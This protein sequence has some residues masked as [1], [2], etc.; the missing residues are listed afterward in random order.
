MTSTTKLKLKNY[1]GCV[2]THFLATKSMQLCINRISYNTNCT[3]EGRDFSFTLKNKT[4]RNI[5]SSG[6]ILFL[7]KD[8]DFAA[9]NWK[10][11]RKILNTGAEKGTWQERREEEK[12]GEERREELVICI[13]VA[14][15][16][17]LTL[18]KKKQCTKMIWLAIDLRK[19]VLLLLLLHYYS[20]YYEYE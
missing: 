17:N 5:T 14:F 6:L 19:P 10:N 4:K 13:C 2:F 11:T 20:Y 12:W 7:Y 15:L 3:F 8:I 1:F 9:E 18:R 16:F